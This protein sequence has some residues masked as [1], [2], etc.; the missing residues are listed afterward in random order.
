MLNEGFKCEVPLTKEMYIGR[1]EGILA[2]TVV[3]RKRWNKF[4]RAQLELPIYRDIRVYV[5]LRTDVLC[6]D[7]ANF[8]TR[9]TTRKRERK[10]EKG[11]RLIDE[12]RGIGTE[13]SIGERKT[14]GRAPKWNRN[15]AR[16]HGHTRARE[17]A[18]VFA[19]CTRR[20]HENGSGPKRSFQGK[21]MSGT[22]T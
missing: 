18:C 19:K 9:E 17:G 2:T 3:S 1:L 20:A 11:S 14:R 4:E 15:V 7:D 12:V 16:R 10:G 21:E 6:A 8:R 22:R 13:V 5:W